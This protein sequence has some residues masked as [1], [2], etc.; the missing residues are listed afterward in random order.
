MEPTTQGLSNEDMRR[1]A[2]LLAARLSS[3][4][5]KGGEKGDARGRGLPNDAWIVDFH[6]TCPQ[7]QMVVNGGRIYCY[8][9]PHRAVMLLGYESAIR[10]DMDAVMAAEFEA[11]PE[12]VIAERMKRAQDVPSLAGR[13]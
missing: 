5:T 12:D 2:D 7:V 13:V 10:T 1:L 11:I 4:V 8:C 6:K 9:E 3:A